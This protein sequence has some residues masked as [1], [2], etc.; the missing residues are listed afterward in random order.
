MFDSRTKFLTALVWVLAALQLLMQPAS[1]L[2]HSGCETHSHGVANRHS[3]DNTSSPTAAKSIWQ[4][5]EEVWHSVTHSGCCKHSQPEVSLTAAKT[6]ARSTQTHQ[7]SSS[8]GYCSRKAAQAEDSHKAAKNSDDQSKDSS[9]PPHDSHQCKICQV[10][11]AA[12]L[13]AVSVKVPTQTDFVRLDDTPALPTV[14]I[15]PR[16]Q[17]PT[18]GPPVA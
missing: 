1:G 12:R 3:A 9:V 6:T 15:A 7:C 17:L 8:C 10:L 16:F 2:L 5:I 4:S 18:R 11:F 14:E 13:N